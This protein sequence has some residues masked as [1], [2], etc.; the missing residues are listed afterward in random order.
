MEATN[1]MDFK[2]AVENKEGIVLLGAGG[3]LKEWI[4][5]IADLLVK[6]GIAKVAANE[7]FKEYYMLK[8]TGGRTD[9]A[10]VFEPDSLHMGK[11]TMWRIRFGDCSW[12]SDYT[13]NY[14]H[15]FIKDGE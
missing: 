10:L 4:N 11:M 6:E 1:F 13:V 2:G 14:E 7:L 3:D 9:L 15:H 8:T 12:I 5:G